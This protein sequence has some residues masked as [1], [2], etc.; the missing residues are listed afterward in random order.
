MSVFFCSVI[1]KQY[2]YKYKY[3]CKYKCCFPKIKA[4]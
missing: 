4:K 2:K 1:H 3:K